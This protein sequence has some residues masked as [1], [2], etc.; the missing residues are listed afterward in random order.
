[1][2]NSLEECSPR[3]AAMISSLRAFGYDLSMA[4]ADLI[5][6]SIFAQA[7]NISVDYD[8]NEG[9][10]WFRITDDGAGMTESSRAIPK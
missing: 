6:N 10:P 3:P 9:D 5:D 7:K 1:M 4:I 8:W 2:I